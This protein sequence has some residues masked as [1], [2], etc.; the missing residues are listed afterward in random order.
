MV[1]LVSQSQ[2]WPI[3]RR[4]DTTYIVQD[5]EG[6]SPTAVSI[7]DGMENTAA[8]DGRQ[9]LLNVQGQKNTTDNGQVQVVDEEE[10]LELEGLTVAHELAASKNDDVVDDDEDGRGLECRH[11]RLEGDELELA[12]GISH[13]SRPCLVE[14]GPEMDSKGAVERW[15]R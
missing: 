3:G 6:L 7:A 10:R 14:D 8:N 11:G 1:S 4:K 15:Q 2:G 12:G 13:H 9:K 5:N